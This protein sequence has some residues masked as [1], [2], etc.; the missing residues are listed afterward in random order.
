MVEPSLDGV[1]WP[2][3]RYPCAIAAVLERVLEK[4]EKKTSFVCARLGLL[5]G[6]TRLCCQFAFGCDML[7]CLTSVRAESSAAC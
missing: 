3:S 1:G 4:E 2:Q 6:P 5:W 7:F